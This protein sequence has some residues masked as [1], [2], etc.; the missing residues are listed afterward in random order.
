MAKRHNSYL[1]LNEAMKEFI[2]ENKLRKGLDKVDARKAWEDI[3]GA[4]VNSYTSGVELRNE[5]LFVSLTSSV[6][7]E[8]L[9]LGKSKII[10]MLNE[11]LGQELIKRLVLR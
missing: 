1:P 9:S 3:M 11:A 5:V 2:D 4:G 8:E 7:R 10:A 6:L